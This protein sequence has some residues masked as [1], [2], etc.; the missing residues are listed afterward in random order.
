MKRGRYVKLEFS[1]HCLVSPAS[2]SDCCYRA[3]MTMFWSDFQL[4]LKIYIYFSIRTFYLN[5]TLS[6]FNNPKFSS[7]E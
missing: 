1:Y 2:L 4:D 7:N 5:N 3:D 6:I